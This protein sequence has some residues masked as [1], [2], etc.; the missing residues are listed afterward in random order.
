MQPETE[1]TVSLQILCNMP[2]VLEICKY[3][4]IMVLILFYLTE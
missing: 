1:V 3:L 4:F 2:R